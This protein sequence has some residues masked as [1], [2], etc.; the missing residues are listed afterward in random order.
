MLSLAGAERQLAVRRAAIM[1]RSKVTKLRTE[2]V[3]IADQLAQLP[4][5]REGLLEANSIRALYRA[6]EDVEHSV[7]VLKACVAALKYRVGL[8]V[9]GSEHW[10]A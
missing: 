10:D 8:E 2:A 3:D 6:L 7:D 4:E 1:P 9:S 5:Y